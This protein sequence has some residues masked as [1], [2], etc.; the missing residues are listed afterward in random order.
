MIVLN[1]N[2]SIDYT[3]WYILL[4]TRTIVNVKSVIFFNYQAEF[5]LNRLFIK[6]N[7]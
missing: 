6:L 5:Q 7:S 2:K 4:D 1:R 3:A